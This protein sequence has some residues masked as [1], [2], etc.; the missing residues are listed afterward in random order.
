[1]YPIK[2]R[3][4]SKKEENMDQVRGDLTPERGKGISQDDGEEELPEEEAERGKCGQAAELGRFLA[5]FE[6]CKTHFTN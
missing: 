4:L 3:I 2:R 6:P 1:M 5:L